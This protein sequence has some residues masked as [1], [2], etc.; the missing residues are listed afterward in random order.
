MRRWVIL[1]AGPP[2]L[3]VFVLVVGWLIFDRS[4]ASRVLGN[5]ELAG[6][7]I[8][9]MS[10]AEV[11]AAVDR[12][13]SSLVSTDITVS[14]PTGD[15]SVS[16]IKI[17]LVI[18]REAVTASALVAGRS[19]AGLLKPVRWIG[20]LVSP[21]RVPII[22]E[23]DRAMLARI[24]AAGDPTGR[25][26][27][28]EPTVAVTGG[29]LAAT[30]GA[31]GHGLRSTDV[32]NAIVDATRPGRAPITVEVAPGVLPTAF[33]DEDAVGLLGEADRLT[34]RP[35][36]VRLGAVAASVASSTLQSWLTTQP[37]VDRG[38]D[39]DGD[40]DGDGASL[41][42]AFAA[43]RVIHG[44]VEIVGD[45][46]EPAG[47]SAIEVQDGQLV[48]VPGAPGTRCC[49]AESATLLFDA[50]DR[51]S[52]Q[53]IELPLTTREPD[54]TNAELTALGIR[55]KIG[56]FTTNY[57]AGQSRVVNIHLIADM[58]RGHVIKPGA[59]FSLNGFVG[60]R[61]S[62]HGFVSGGVIENGVF[63]ESVGGGISQFA[64]TIFNAAFF[65]GLDFDSY[66]SH[67]IYI[68][69][70]PYGREATLSFPSPDLVVRNSTPFGV[71]IWTDYTSTSV[72]V[73]LWSTRF[74][75]GE[76]TGQTSNPNGACTRVRTERT[77]TYVDGHTAVDNVFATYQPEEGV[78]C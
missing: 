76:Q 22:V 58:V 50:L 52:T 75:S 42:L 48:V 68:S 10:R 53:T 62:A 33:A 19:G 61:T 37:S 25:V 41:V 24:V 49:A 23:L 38:R 47:G 63:S 26:D 71:F 54:H 69:R 13:A 14:T 44:L 45:I 6:I 27:P 34:A 46:G 57:Q 15:L 1:L 56:E 77:R 12:V 59:T 55:E 32:A 21:T 67:S 40:G 74:A 36:D 7:D 51:R 78:G 8:G 64:T 66:Q 28:V 2:L 31:P 9:G 65:G 30:K 16:P 5:V 17:N 60:P 20:R 3:I 11:G 43:D 29:T 18:D 73:S 39:R 35:A 70:Y 4:D 72:T